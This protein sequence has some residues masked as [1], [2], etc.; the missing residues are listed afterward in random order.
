MVAL[1][2]AFFSP[3]KYGIILFTCLALFNAA[4]AQPIDKNATG[5][6][7][8]LYSNLKAILKKGILFGHQD[9]M[10]YGVQWKYQ[11]GRSDVKDVTGQYPAVFGWELGGLENDLPVNLD[12][13]P[14]DKM[15]TYI[16]KGYEAG[17]V[18][19][20][21]WHLNNP[22]TGKSAWDPAP[23]NTIPSILPGGEKNELYKTWLDKL[24][25]FFKSLKAQNGTYVPVI[26]RPFH[27]LN[28]SWFWWGGK[29]CTPQQLME[30]WK[31]TV[32]YLRDTKQ[33]HQLLYAFNTD[34]FATAAEYL[35]RYPGKEW[36]DI[37]GFDI[38]QKGDILPNDQFIAEL[39]RSLALLEKIAGE[40][41]KI[42]ALTEFGYNSLP[43]TAWWTTVFYKAIHK[44]SIA[45]ALAWRN[46]GPKAGGEIEYYV[47]YRSQQSAADFLQFSRK[48]KIFFQ[49]QAKRLKLYQ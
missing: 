37:L 24:A 47:P 32:G 4:V 9:D 27:E 5:S 34:R 1:T 36:V 35:E 33:V 20:I 28:G 3:K 44:H 19:T 48:K 10:A 16:R 26:F 29:N 45:Y 31:Y 15:K 6:T 23:A 7:K 49:Q 18:I 46:A 21:S 43:D 22:L 11:P 38:Y 2:I 17:A 42:P 12:S 13:V 30:L 40:E 39:D 8:A 25:A 41:K 14:F